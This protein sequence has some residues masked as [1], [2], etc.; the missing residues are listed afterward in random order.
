MVLAKIFRVW[1]VS[2]FDWVFNLFPGDPEK[3]KRPSRDLF[4]LGIRFGKT[5]VHPY[6]CP[7]KKLY[8]T[9][10]KIRAAFKIKE[11]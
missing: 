7:L 11:L 2:K 8:N 3:G 9:Y 4:L 5:H 1:L 6:L 10:G